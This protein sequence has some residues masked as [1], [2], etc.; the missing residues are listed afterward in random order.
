MLQSDFGLRDGAVAAMKGVA[1][2]VDAHLPI[3]DLSRGGKTVRCY[4]ALTD[5]VGAATY[6]LVNNKRACHRWL[7]RHR[8]PVPETYAVIE[9]H[10]DIRRFP[11]MLDGRSDFVVKP[12]EG[13][14]GRGILVIVD[15]QDGAF[16]T[17][18]GQRIS[19]P[20]M[21]YH[22][23]TVLSGLYSLGG[24]PDRAI[25]RRS[26]ARVCVRRC[27]VPVVGTHRIQCHPRILHQ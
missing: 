18:G 17:S 16:V 2:A 26:W 3:F 6:H 12:C 14:E 15:F 8:I 11:E 5:L 27:V 9:R 22:L 23:S 7:A 25:A 24:Q 1:F 21:R 10:G 13:S 4:N 19:V 20:D